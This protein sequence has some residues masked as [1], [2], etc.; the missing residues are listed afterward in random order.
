VRDQVAAGPLD[1]AARAMADLAAPAV[2]LAISS[3]VEA[4]LLSVLVS[5]FWT[6]RAWE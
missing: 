6:K 1:Q 3:G 2:P 4:R 5:H